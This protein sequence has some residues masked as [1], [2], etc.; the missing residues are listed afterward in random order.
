VEEFEGENVFFYK[1]KNYVPINAELQREIVR[2]Y[3][4]HPTAGHPGELQTFNAA[5]EHYLLVARASS[6]YQEL[7]PRM[8]NMSTIQ[9]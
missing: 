6:L 4:D 3:H 2:R 9:N 7:R 1:G 5:K 8:W